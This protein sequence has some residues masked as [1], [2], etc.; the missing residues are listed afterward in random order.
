MHVTQILAGISGFWGSRPITAASLLSIWSNFQCDHRQMLW[1]SILRDQP[2]AEKHQEFMDSVDIE[3]EKHKHKKQRAS[4]GPWAALWT[5]LRYIVL[6]CLMYKLSGRT[7]PYLRPHL[8]FVYEC[9]QWLLVDSVQRRH[10]HLR[11]TCSCRPALLLYCT[12]IYDSC[13][14]YS[15]R[16]RPDT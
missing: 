7:W 13:K 15:L 10:F 9:L 16:L 6:V 2:K 5:P 11:F 4:S 12:F 14:R 3:K 8:M 1:W